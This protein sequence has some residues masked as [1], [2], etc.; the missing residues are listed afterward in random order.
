MQSLSTLATS[1]FTPK[2]DEFQISPAASPEI[3]YHIAQYGELS[4]S[5][6]T[7]M[8][9]NYTITILTTSI[10]YTLPL[11]RSGEFRYQLG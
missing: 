1:P 6:L 7:Q 8:E 4:F 10:I 3:L 9:E 11:N 2:S 5:K